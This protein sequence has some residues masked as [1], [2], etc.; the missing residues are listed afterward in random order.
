MG[1]LCYR[2]KKKHHVSTGLPGEQFQCSTVL[3]NYTGTE[4]A[5]NCVWRFALFIS[6]NSYSSA[7]GTSK[8]AWC[9]DFRIVF[10]GGLGLLIEIDNGRLDFLEKQL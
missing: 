9:N 10:Q 4:Q 3:E 1:L 7:T 5:T 2:A 6:L 8:I